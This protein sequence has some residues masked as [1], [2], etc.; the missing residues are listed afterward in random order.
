[1]ANVVILTK[2]AE[3]VA[4]YDQVLS[5]VSDDGDYTVR[6]EGENMLGQK[7]I[8]VSRDSFKFKILVFNGLG[9]EFP[10]TTLVQI[11]VPSGTFGEESVVDSS[12]AFD[13][14]VAT[15]KEIYN[16]IEVSEKATYSLENHQPMHAPLS[17]DDLP[18]TD[19]AFL[20]WL[21]IFPP[22]EVEAIGHDHLLAAPAT[23]VREFDDGSVLLVSKHPEDS[24]P[25]PLDEVAEHLGIRSWEDYPNERASRSDFDE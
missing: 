20:T 13:S 7:R 8:N 11:N 18:P 6:N 17:G 2:G 9:D 14:V 12:A 16:E 19:R 5:F 15:T 23:R 24:D 22:S 21:D 4:L 3:T 10:E 1:M 25:D